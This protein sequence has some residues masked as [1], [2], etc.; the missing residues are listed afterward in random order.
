MPMGT[1]RCGLR[2]SRASVAIASKPRL[3]DE[4]DGRRAQDPPPSI[5]SEPF[6]RQHKRRP[7][8]RMNVQAAEADHDQQRA[9]FERHND[10]IDDARQPRNGHPASTVVKNQDVTNSKKSIFNATAISFAPS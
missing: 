1:L 4:Y 8:A 9:H 7:I 3:R 2:V 10:C 6:I 5:A